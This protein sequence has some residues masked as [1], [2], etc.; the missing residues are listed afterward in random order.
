M[1]ADC[2]HEA[3]EVQAQGAIRPEKAADLLDCS[4]AKVYQ[5]M[6]AGEL[7][8]FKIGRS[9]RIRLVDIHAYVARELSAQ[10]GSSQ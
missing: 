3:Q 7:P 9:R 6:K 10:L 4:R 5:L 1:A 8:S 2:Q